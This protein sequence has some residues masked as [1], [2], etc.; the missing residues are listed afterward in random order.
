MN[1]S[2][3]GP[4][5]AIERLPGSAVSRLHDLVRQRDT[6]RA[7]F[8][9]VWDAIAPSTAAR[10]LEAWSAAV[11]DLADVNAG[12]ACLIAFW[13][14][15]PPCRCARRSRRD[16]RAGARVTIPAPADRR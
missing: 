15:L 16:R 5:R 10:E 12:P 11:L 8:Y 2:G 7:T 4:H 3:I 1:P 13:R 14:N 6:L 9:G